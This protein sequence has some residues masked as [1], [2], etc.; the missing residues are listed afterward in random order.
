MNTKFSSQRDENNLA[1]L[2]PTLTRLKLNCDA[3]LSLPSI[4]ITCEVR[5]SMTR[6]TL[7]VFSNVNTMNQFILYF[8]NL[9]ELTIIDCLTKITPHNIFIEERNFNPTTMLT[10]LKQVT[11]VKAK[12]PIHPLTV[13]QRGDDNVDY[14]TFFDAI[15]SLECI[16]IG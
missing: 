10:R 6:L 11:I 3:F 9:E 15:P 2:P 4:N 7:R 5:K 16:R 1:Y 14:S 13:I 12:V 8:I